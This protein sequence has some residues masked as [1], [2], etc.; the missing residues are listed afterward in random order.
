MLNRAKSRGNFQPIKRFLRG[1]SEGCFLSISFLL[2][3]ISISVHCYGF[4]SKLPPAVGGQACRKGNAAAHSGS[5]E[6]VSPCP[7]LLQQGLVLALSWVPA[8]PFP[9]QQ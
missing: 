4:E 9:L 1:V 3:P 2:P 7:P 8:L 5:H 6:R